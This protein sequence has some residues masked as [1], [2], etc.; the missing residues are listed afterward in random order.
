MSHKLILSVYVSRIWFSCYLDI[1]FWQVDPKPAYQ[2][3]LTQGGPRAVC[4]LP[5]GRQPHSTAS[6]TFLLPLH[7]LCL[8]FL[9][10]K[11][12]CI[13]DYFLLY[14][15]SIF[16]FCFNCLLS[17]VTSLYTNF[18]FYFSCFTYLSFNLCL[19]AAFTWRPFFHISC[20]TIYWISLSYLLRL[21]FLFLIFSLLFFI[22]IF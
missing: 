14:K 15:I 21:H 4:K 1:L 22:T 12:L 19:F 13:L 5:P 20:F 8:F 18:I 11:I 6:L 3:P 2:T 16:L 7:F 17:W 10:Y 9:F